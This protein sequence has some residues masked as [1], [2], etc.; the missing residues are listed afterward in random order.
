[1]RHTR[2][3]R[4]WSSDVCSSDLFGVPRKTKLRP[5]TIL[6]ILRMV[7]DTLPPKIE[8]GRPI[9]AGFIV[10]VAR[11]ILPAGAEQKREVGPRVPVEIGR[12]SC[13]EGVEICVGHA[14]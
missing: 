3:T 4:D 7:G 2:S 9:D 13:R 8:K 1:R 5:E 11:V 12:A 6:G 14:V 10:E